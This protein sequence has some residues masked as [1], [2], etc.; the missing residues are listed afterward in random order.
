MDLIVKNRRDVG[1]RAHGSS[2]GGLGL[3]VKKPPKS[4]IKRHLSFITG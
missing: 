4:P 1:V 2:H 3:T